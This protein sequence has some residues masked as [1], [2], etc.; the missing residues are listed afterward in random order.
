MISFEDFM[1]VDGCP[2]YLQ[3]IQYI[4]RGIASKT[5]HN[6]EEAP[7]RRALSAL[8][9]VNPNTIQK[10]YHNLEEE[11]ILTSRS[12]AKSYLCIDQKTV[13]RIRRELLIGDTKEWVNAMKQ[14]N[15]SKEEAFSLA[16]N[17]WTAKEL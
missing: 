3:I 6:G 8:L 5:I 15:I 1:F 14:L 17:I 11:G 2:I 9:G 16:E 4:K 12:G 13:E 7:S 10:A